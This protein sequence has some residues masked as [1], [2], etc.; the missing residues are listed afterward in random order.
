MAE[1]VVLCHK[2]MYE[3]LYEKNYADGHETYPAIV[4][5]VIQL[6]FIGIISSLKSIRSNLLQ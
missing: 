2:K 1:S 6:F 4:V 5:V 3:Y